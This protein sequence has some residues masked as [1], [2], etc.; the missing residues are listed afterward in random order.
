MK[1]AVS[2]EEKEEGRRA[3]AHEREDG[4]VGCWV[5]SVDCERP[6]DGLGEDEQREEGEVL[7]KL[8]DLP[9]YDLPDLGLAPSNAKGEPEGLKLVKIAGLDCQLI[10]LT[11]GGHV[12]RYRGLDNEET[13]SRRGGCWEYLP[14][15][16]E[17]ER[18][19]GC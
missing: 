5:W 14:G 19:K 4:S 12:V 16:C 1:K 18:V 10:G 9:V 3:K 13:A 2:E 11:N 8:P 6:D 17:K 7:A 15:F